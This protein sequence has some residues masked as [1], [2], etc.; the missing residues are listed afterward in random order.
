MTEPLRHRDHGQWLGAFATRIEVN[1]PRCGHAGTV[2]ADAR[3][4]AHFVCGRCSLD[5]RSERNDWL[6]Q[7]RLSGRRPCGYCGHQW[8]CVDRIRAGTLRA[9]IELAPWRTTPTDDSLAVACPV[10]KHESI[11]AIDAR[12]ERGNEGY[13]PHF[14]LPLRLIERT[15]AGLLWA[16]NGEHIDELRRYVSADLRERHRTLGNKTMIS[17]L[18]TWMKLARHRPL[19]LKALDRLSRRLGDEAA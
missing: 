15:R 2:H 8:L 4:V 9:P 7:V 14:G 12:R 6:G 1:C 16:Y 3:W 5:A 13:D 10:C 19:M 18:P 11:V 17:R